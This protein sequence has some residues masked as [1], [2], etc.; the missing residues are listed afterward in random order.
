MKRFVKHTAA[1]ALLAIVSVSATF[2]QTAG[3][4]TLRVLFI[5]NSYT[6]FNNLPDLVAGVAAANADGPAIEPAF[7]TR[8]GATL[9]WHLENGSALK[10]LSTGKWDF[11]VLQ[12]QSLLGGGEKDGK[13][14][15]GNPADFH[16]SVREWV[17]RIRSV[18]ATPLLF[19]TW[20]RRDPAD[21]PRVQKELADAY[22]TIGKELNVKVAPVGLAWAETRRRLR[23][24]DLHVWD[25]S[26][27][28]SAG[29][30]LAALVIYA[31]LTG[32]NPTGAPAVIQGRPTVDTATET[33]LDPS[34]RVPLADLREATAT[35]L[36][37]IAWKIHS[38][39]TA[40]N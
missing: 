1:V 36:Q 28:S 30:Y 38:Q 13:T 25:A 33:V 9:R 12:E 39:Q 20:A 26:H 2:A 17:K 35:A 3:R 7:A 34:I 4:L 23:T 37:E 16:E 24:L 18:G 10:A 29:S 32:R 15:V 14:I 8:G 5:G 40:T 6:Y 27:P 19:M 22:N 11:V 21:A 31:T